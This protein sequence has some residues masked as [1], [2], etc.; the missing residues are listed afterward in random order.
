MEN[1]V[2]LGVI[3]C[4]TLSGRAFKRVICDFL[5][6]HVQ[7]W[8]QTLDQK[9]GIYVAPF[10]G[11][12]ERFAAWFLHRMFMRLAKLWVVIIRLKILVLGS[13]LALLWNGI[14]TVSPLVSSPCKHKLRI[15]KS[16][17][18]LHNLPAFSTSLNRLKCSALFLSP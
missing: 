1:Q 11:S 12:L 18:I 3:L 13:E 14:L 17:K 4:A 2:C 10:F 15:P 9:N 16:H 5:K 7:N 8:K 6:M